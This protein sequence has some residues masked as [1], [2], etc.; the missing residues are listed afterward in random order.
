[1][2]EVQN[3]KEGDKGEKEFIT[4][5]MGVQV[6]CCVGYPKKRRKILYGKLRSEIGTILRRMC[7]YKG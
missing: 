7:E 4:H 1:M 6:S 5:S 3:I 2:L